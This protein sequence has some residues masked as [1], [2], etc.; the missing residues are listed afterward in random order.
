[1]NNTIYVVETGMYSDTHI[2]GVFTSVE[3]AQ[4]IID[5]INKNEEW[6]EEYRIKPM[7]L[8]PAINELNAG[9]RMYNIS[10]LENGDT[11]SVHVRDK[12]DIVMNNWRV[13]KWPNSNKIRLFVTV[14]AI[15][16]K[17]AVKIANE[18]RTQLIALNQFTHGS[19]GYW[20]DQEEND[21]EG[22]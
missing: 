18:R 5:Y 7:Q 22:T 21:K 10:M 15:D 14:W 19:K 12:D 2:V 20:H 9:L 16:D 11:E 3:N 8:D 17:H 1:M 13:M 6:P 4:S